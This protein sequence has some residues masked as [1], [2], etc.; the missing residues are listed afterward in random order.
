MENVNMTFEKWI[1][2]FIN[3]KGIDPEHVITV[4]G[5]SGDNFMPVGSVIEAM[6]ITPVQEQGAI[7]DTLVKID[8]MNG[9]PMHFIQ[10]IA[11]ALA[12]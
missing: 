5:P 12:I 10:H 2:V 9:N 8:V 3:E 4:P 11:G 1:D 6:K 7:K